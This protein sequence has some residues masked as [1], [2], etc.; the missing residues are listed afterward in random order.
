MKDRAL[1]TIGML[2]LAVAAGSVAYLIS[3]RQNDFPEFEVVNIYATSPSEQ[4]QGRTITVN[5]RSEAYYSAI[6]ERPIFSPTRRPFETEEAMVDPVETVVEPEITETELRL[7]GVLHS[8]VGARALVSVYGLE[9]DWIAVG[10]FIGDIEVL[11]IGDDWLQLKTE[12][13]MVRLELFE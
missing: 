4:V 9:P 2:C 3:S 10:Q 11:E 1:R 8:D 6:L 7:L 5:K 13:G 12:F